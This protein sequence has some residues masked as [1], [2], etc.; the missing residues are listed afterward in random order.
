LI[1]LDFQQGTLNNIKKVFSFLNV[2]LAFFLEFRELLAEIL[3]RTQKT[4]RPL[5]F[6]QGHLNSH[7]GTPEAGM[8]TYKNNRN[9][10]F[11]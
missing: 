8:A 9:V 3:K 2:T 1:K 5:F 4:R 11:K 6:R 10:A 7:Y